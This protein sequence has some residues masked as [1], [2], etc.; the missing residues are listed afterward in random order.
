M[1]QTERVKIV[2]LAARPGI[3]LALR[4][5]AGEGWRVGRRSY[6]SLT[7]AR[8][9]AYRMKPKCDTVFIFYPASAACAADAITA[10]NYASMLA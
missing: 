3:N 7:S 10:N 1:L 6:P 4:L 8:E 9:A 5:A 2:A